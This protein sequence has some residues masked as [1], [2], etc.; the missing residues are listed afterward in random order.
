VLREAKAGPTIGCWHD[1]AAMR[2]PN[3]PAILTMEHVPEYRAALHHRDAGLERTVVI[4][5]T[6]D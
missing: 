2:Y 6:P 1:V 5:S 3:P 4:A